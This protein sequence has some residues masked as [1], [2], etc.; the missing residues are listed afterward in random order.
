VINGIIDSLDVQGRRNGFQVK[1]GNALSQIVQFKFASPNTLPEPAVT[2]QINGASVALIASEA[3]SLTDSM[4]VAY[5]QAV[6]SA[7]DC[8]IHL[9][10]CPY[11]RSTKVNNVVI[12]FIT[13]SW[14]DIQFGA[15]YLIAGNYPCATLLSN[16]LSLSSHEHQ[17]QICAWV[18]ALG[19]H[20]IRV[21]DELLVESVESHDPRDVKVKLFSNNRVF[22]PLFVRGGLLPSVRFHLSDLLSRFYVLFSCSALRDV[23]VFPVGVVGYPSETQKTFREVMAE[24]FQTFCD[25]KGTG[26]VDP[27]EYLKSV[28]FP[29]LVYKRLTAPWC[30]GDLMTKEYFHVKTAFVQKLEAALKHCESAGIIHLDVRLYNLF[31]RK[32]EDQVDIKIID[33]DDSFRVGYEIPEEILAGRRRDARFPRGAQFKIACAEYHSFFL[34]KIKDELE[35]S[36]PGSPSLVSVN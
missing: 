20:C 10:K 9:I 19:N 18:T 25:L 3:K 34:A 30:R 6:Q 35:I 16:R 14:E 31:Y 11:M 24:A 17:I 5:A 33:W 4:Y 8:A 12:P 21:I 15:V 1:S 28:G 2:Y 36:S 32:R 7:A 23:V 13:T 22:K 29:Y 26:D 27:E